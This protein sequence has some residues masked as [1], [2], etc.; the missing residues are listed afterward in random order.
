MVSGEM[1]RRAS[2]SGEEPP[3]GLRKDGEWPA[4]VRGRRVAIIEDELMVAWS[5]ESTL[6]D[7][8]YAVTATYSRGEA[9]IDRLDG[10]SVDIIL[11]DINLGPERLDGIETARRLRERTDA[12]FVF[13]SAYADAATVAR[14]K[15]E[16]PGALLLRKPVATALLAA[17]LAQVN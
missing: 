15:A 8:G 1:T 13:I 17:A 10:A 3:P 4:S 14:V 2:G 7:L 11:L 12:R 5:M 6:D 16:I 9:A